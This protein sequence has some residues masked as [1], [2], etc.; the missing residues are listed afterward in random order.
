MN[1]EGNKVY[2]HGCYIADSHVL[3]YGDYEQ[4]GYPTVEIRN[5][6]DAREIR[7]TISL[8]LFFGACVT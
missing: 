4:V 5:I 2:P 1:Y 7:N 3:V 6:I 8:V